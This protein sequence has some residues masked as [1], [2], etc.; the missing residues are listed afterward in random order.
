MKPLGYVPLNNLYQPK[1]VKGGCW[2]NGFFPV[3]WFEKKG[4]QLKR[5]HLLIELPQNDKI[6]VWQVVAV[7]KEENENKEGRVV[8]RKFFERMIVEK[9]KKII[10][11]RIYKREIL[12]IFKQGQFQPLQR[13]DYLYLSFDEIEIDTMI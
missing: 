6:K 13:K 10:K 9:K 1:P 2:N 5:G 4:D 12:R 7:K 11:H 3:R 8:A